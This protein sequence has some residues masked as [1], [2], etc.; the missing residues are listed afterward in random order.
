MFHGR[1]V[2]ATVRHPPGTIAAPT[3]VGMRRPRAHGAWFGYH[4]TTRGTLRQAIFLDDHDRSQFL[5]LL[6]RTWRLDALVI[7]SYCL[8]GNHYHLD[9]ETPR[10]NVS[11]AMHRVNAG[12]AQYF[13]RRHAREGHVFERRYRSTLIVTD[14]QAMATMRYIVRNPVR[15][16]LCAAPED[17]AWSSHRAMLGLAAPPPFLDLDEALDLFGPGDARVGRYRAYVDEGVDAPAERPPLA[18][19]VADGSLRA[20]AEA[21]QRYRYPLRE[22][23]AVVGISPATLSRRLRD[24]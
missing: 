17:W 12:Y 15:A 10:A 14:G 13:N 20:I 9:V 8:M 11:G 22:I 6:S 5:A 4:V 16:G 19:V 7:R 1:R 2:F 18:E 21:N 23:A 24:P 3:V